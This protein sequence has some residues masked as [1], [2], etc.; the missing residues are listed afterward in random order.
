M[1][2]WDNGRDEPYRMAFNKRD[3]YSAYTFDTNGKLQTITVEGVEQTFSTSIKAPDGTWDNA[4]R[5]LLAM[6]EDMESDEMEFGD[7]HRRLYGC[8]DCE[9]TWDTMC[10]VGL[11]DVCAV[12]ASGE[13]TGDARTAVKIFCTKFTKECDAASGEEICA[14]DCTEDVPEECDPNPCENGGECSADPAGGHVCD[15]PSGYGGMA[16]QTDTSSLDTFVIEVEYIGTWTSTRR[17]VFESA[18]ARWSEVITHVPCGGNN[19]YPAGRLLITATLAGIDGSG[20][21]LGSAGPTSV[22]SSCKTIS[23]LGAMTFDID[24]IEGLEDAGT[25]EGVIQHEMGHVIGIGTLWGTGYGDCTTCYDDG[26]ASWTCPAALS[27]YHDIGGSDADFLETG[28]GTGTSCGHL[29]EAIFDDE[30]MTGYV[31]SV[32]YLSK[33]TTAILDDLDYIVD[34]SAVDSYTLPSER[35]DSIR[36]DKE[37]SIV[38][39]DT[40]VKTTIH[41]VDE[42]GTVEEKE[43]IMMV[44]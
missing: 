9:N 7:H 13:L 39:N 25:F 29:D 12:V 6:Q 30:L 3:I 19:D 32:M 40:P 31:D 35:G 10:N 24:D 21:T 33:M 28:G 43:G 20:G 36:A 17:A 22:W 16:C 11:A 4:S 34:A 42:D 18:A 23:L 1:Y 37:R 41:L 5:K 38:I 8:S 2:W 26:D 14:D 15:C 27:A 44:F